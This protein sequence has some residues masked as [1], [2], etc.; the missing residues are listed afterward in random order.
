MVIRCF[1]SG[2]SDRKMGRSR[3]L[4]PPTPGTTN[5]CSNQLS[6]DRHEPP[7]GW[8]RPAPAPLKDAPKRTQAEQRWLGRSHG[9]FPFP[10][11]SV[12]L[13]LPD[14]DRGTSQMKRS[15]LWSILCVLALLTPFSMKGGAR[16]A[17]KLG[18]SRCQW[19]RPQLLRNSRHADSCRAEAPAF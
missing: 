2:K 9:R 6:Y 10:L 1:G 3:G 11:L 19:Q 15:A 18:D 5:Q 4:E 8:F 16:P 13:S 17:P 14:G 12:S 7:S